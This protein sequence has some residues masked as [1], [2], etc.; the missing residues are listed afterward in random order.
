MKTARFAAVVEVAGNPHTHLLLVLPEKD[1]V[2][3]AAI[4]A[5][6]VMTVHQDLSETKQITGPLALNPAGHGNS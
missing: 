6:R 3:Q 4:K 5:H 1:K 2:L